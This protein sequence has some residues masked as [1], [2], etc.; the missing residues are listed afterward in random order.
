MLIALARTAL[1]DAEF[2]PPWPNEPIWA[3]SAIHLVGAFQNAYYYGLW[4]SNGPSTIRQ[5]AVRLPRDLNVFLRESILRQLAIGVEQKA[6]RGGFAFTA[7]GQ[8]LQEVHRLRATAAFMDDR[9]IMPALKKALSKSVMTMD[10]IAANFV[11]Q[12]RA[13]GQAT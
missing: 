5:L 9:R 2:Y 8:R 6:V 10:E 1:N 13:T 4:T 12:S 7:S 3:T 11:A